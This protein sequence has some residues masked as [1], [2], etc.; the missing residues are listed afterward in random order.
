M[1]V[2]VSPRGIYLDVHKVFDRIWWPSPWGSVIAALEV[3]YT[4]DI[5]LKAPCLSNSYRWLNQLTLGFVSSG[6]TGTSTTTGGVTN[7]IAGDTRG[8]SSRLCILRSTG[9]T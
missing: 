2:G 8:I 9:S 3:S 6:K 5:S 1:T 4:F 7:R